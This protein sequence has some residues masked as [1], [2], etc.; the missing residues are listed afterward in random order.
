MM[1]DSVLGF[2]CFTFKNN[3]N[4]KVHDKTV[5]L[6]TPGCFLLLQTHKPAVHSDTALGSQSIP[7]NLIPVLG[8]L[9]VRYYFL[10]A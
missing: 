9:S 3:N 4:K 6:V 5:S 7:M 8:L 10:F 1:H 2:F